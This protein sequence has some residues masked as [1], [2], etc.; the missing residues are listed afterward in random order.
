MASSDRVHAF[1]MLRH[2]AAAENFR[3]AVVT[4]K[5]VSSAKPEIFCNASVS[6]VRG[7]A[8][9]GEARQIRTEAEYT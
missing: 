4:M 8:G 1:W 9:P 7:K 5:I 6:L 2:G 3:S